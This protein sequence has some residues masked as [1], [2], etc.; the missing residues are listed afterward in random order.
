MSFVELLNA[1]HM[2]LQYGLEGI[3]V[4]IFGVLGWAYFKGG[5]L[6]MNSKSKKLCNDIDKLCI[7]MNLVKKDIH[8]HQ[9]KMDKLSGAVSQIQGELKRIK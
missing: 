9:T 5:V 3:L 6:V 1:L 2:F 7:D 8:K 4:L